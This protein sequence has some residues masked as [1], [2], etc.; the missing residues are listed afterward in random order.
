[1]SKLLPLFIAATGLSELDIRAILLNGPSRY[2]I[3]PIK[4][5]NGDDRWIAQPA[6]ELKAL[7]HAF[8]EGFLRHLPVHPAATAYRSGLSIKDNAQRHAGSGPILKYDFEDFF[9]SIRSRDWRAYCDAHAILGDDWDRWATER[10]LFHR[11]KGSSILRLSVGAPSSPMLSNVLM[12]DFDARMVEAVARDKVVYTRYADDLTF[13]APRTGYLNAV[14][15]ALRRTI[16][17]VQWPK[18]VINARK[19]ARITS[20]YSRHVTGL[21]LANDGKISI[22]REKKRQLRAEIDHAKKGRKSP[23][24]MARL[25]GMLAFVNAVEPEFLQKLEG[26]YGMEVFGEIKKFANLSLRR[27]PKA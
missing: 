6:R 12:Y 17:S 21:V 26:H 22:G 14:D 2:K 5:R 1:M 3:F 27:R 23:Q 8:I 24:E 19:T 10:L 7:Q 20:K 4:K 16:R 9:P 13:S 25:C 11:L 15:A 18:L